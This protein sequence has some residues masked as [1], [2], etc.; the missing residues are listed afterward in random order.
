MAKLVMEA[1]VG[2]RVLGEVEETTLEEVSLV[3][4]FDVVLR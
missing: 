4:V 2:S 1:V 3:L